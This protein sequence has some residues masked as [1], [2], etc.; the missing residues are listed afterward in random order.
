MMESLRYLRSQVFIFE[1][2]LRG[3]YAEGNA[4]NEKVEEAKVNL[5][6]ANKR[7]LDETNIIEEATRNI[8]EAR[9]E[10]SQADLAVENYLR[11]GVDILPFAAAP[12]E[13]GFEPIGTGEYAI[14]SWSEFVR[15]AYGNVEP[16]FIGTLDKLYEFK[17]QNAQGEGDCESSELKAVSGYILQVLDDRFVM[18]TNEGKQ[19]AISYSAC[20]VTLA[21]IQSY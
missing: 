12:G 16:L 7:Y 10:K 18:I 3:A 14:K 17:L 8:E 21:N 4:A 20:I 19:Y 6:A 9:I 1:K 5:E 13:E 11:E 15:I 2:E